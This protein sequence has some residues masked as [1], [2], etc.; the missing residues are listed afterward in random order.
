MLIA[1]ALGRLLQRLASRK[2]S[3]ERRLENTVV[4]FLGILLHGYMKVP[5]HA[6]HTLCRPSYK[7]QQCS[8]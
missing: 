1:D 6:A 4:P 8:A 2:L 3:I 7:E 5:T